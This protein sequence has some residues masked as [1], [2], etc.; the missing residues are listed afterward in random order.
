MAVLSCEQVT[1]F[2][3]PDGV[4]DHVHVSHRRASECDPAAIEQA[5]RGELRFVCN[6]GRA[7]Q[8]LARMLGLMA[9]AAQMRK[10]ALAMPDVEE[11][12]HFGKPDFR[13]SG[14]IFAGLSEDEKTGTLKLT[15]EI[16][17]TVFS[18]GSPFTPC[19]GQWGRSGWTYVDLKRVDVAVL[20]ALLTEAWQ[21]VAPKAK[22]KK[23][24][25][26]K[27]KLTAKRRR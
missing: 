27:K 17:S 9:T 4:H 12:S 26:A 20:D 6:R 3:I 14:K 10:L 19:A 24:V 15:A 22:P 1:R 8:T 2:V 11:K 21:I 5:R 7:T 16:Q 25:T 23:K 18:D 13:V